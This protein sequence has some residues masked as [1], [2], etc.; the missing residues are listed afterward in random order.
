VVS[1]TPLAFSWR[2]SSRTSVNDGSGCALLS[3][4]G[5][6]VRMFLSNMPWNKPM[7]WSPFFMISQFCAW[8][9]ANTEKPNF[10]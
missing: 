1:D 7:T 3:H 2:W 4:P 9:P 8:L 5:L 6:K 10:S